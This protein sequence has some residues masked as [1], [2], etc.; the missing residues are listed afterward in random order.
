MI[1]RRYVQYIQSLVTSDNQIIR[2][3]AHLAVGS[4]RSTTGR[5]IREIRDE[6]GLDPLTTSK[7]HFFVKKAEVP[8]HGQDNIEL[9]DHLLYIRNSETE[10]DIIAEVDDLISSVC[11]V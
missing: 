3:L 11:S 9:L 5:N 10:E 4:T 1:L 6:F 7:K 8:E 2:Q